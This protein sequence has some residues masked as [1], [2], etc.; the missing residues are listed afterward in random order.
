[1]SE[2]VTESTTTTIPA[3][4]ATSTDLGDAGKR[5]LESERAARREA[6]KSAKDATAT[7]ADLQKR[8]DEHE[9]ATRTDSEKVLRRAE[10]AENDLSAAQGA[11]QALQTR[12]ERLEV[13]L[14]HALGE[15]D[16]RRL[17]KAADRLLGD[18]RIDWESDVKDVLGAFQATTQ[19]AA[20]D[21]GQGA[22]TTATHVAST[23][24]GRIAA[25]LAE[26]MK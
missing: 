10:K 12:A 17:T 19:R 7:I 15:D 11:T 25:G 16:A 1:M 2:S 8:V 26:H 9:N 3:A 14:L 18:T 20:G 24:E 21:I 4:D 23:P 22:R 13:V 5:A 6:E